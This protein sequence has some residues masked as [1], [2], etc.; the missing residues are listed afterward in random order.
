MKT[1]ITSISLLLINMI[2]F[3]S[4]FEEEEKMNLPPTEGDVQ[5]GVAALTETYEYQVYYD[6]VTNTTVKT[7]TFD[8]WDLAFLCS[9]TAWHIRLNNAKFMYA[10]NSFNTNFEEVT[11]DDGIEMYFDRSDGD[12]DSLAIKDWLDLSG[13]NPVSRNHVYVIDRGY[14]EGY[15]TVGFVK[16]IFETPQDNTYRIRFADLDG[17][18]EQT[19][20]IEKDTTI[21]YVC[22]SFDT[23]I[24]DIEPP[25]TEWTLLFS[26]YQTLYQDLFGNY[27]PYL[28]KGALLNPH[29]VT[30]NMDTLLNF[31]DITI[32]DIENFEFKT[33]LDIIGH[34]WKYFNFEEG[35]YSVLSEQNYLIQN[36]DGYYYRLH[37]ID[38]YNE[39]NEK[40]YPTFEFARL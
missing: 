21:N 20:I 33:E 6:L 2:F 15:S 32:T 8:K 36:N 40:G 38:Y 30:A 4:C 14:G 19:V 31:S 17:E 10:G 39:T 26:L 12:V 24:A 23:G 35:Y 16:V 25:K 18:N 3:S 5:I 13:E 1:I 7:N 27:Q 29:N 34:D 22:F 9:D 28:V 11:N 37:F